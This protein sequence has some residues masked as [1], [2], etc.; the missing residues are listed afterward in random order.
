MS[1]MTIEL[2]EDIMS[3]VGLSELRPLDAT[4]ANIKF[5]AKGTLHVMCRNQDDKL[6][7]DIPIKETTTEVNPVREY[8]DKLD[9]LEKAKEG[10]K[11]SMLI[12]YL[13]GLGVM[14]LLGLALVVLF[15]MNGGL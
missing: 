2:G 9:E 4:Q 3:Q 7:K 13:F 11:T 14:G 6:L 5:D 12:L 15:W 1:N 8:F 10:R